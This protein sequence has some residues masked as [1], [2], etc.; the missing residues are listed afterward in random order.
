MS[1]LEAPVLLQESW[2]WHIS[3]L[4]SLS[5]RMSWNLGYWRG[6]PGLALSWVMVF[7]CSSPSAECLRHFGFWRHSD[8]SRRCRAE[9]APVT[10][11]IREWH[12]LLTASAHHILF[13]ALLA[14]P[15]CAV[16]NLAA[17]KACWAV[18][19]SFHS[20]GWSCSWW[21]EGP[22][23]AAAVGACMGRKELLLLAWVL[24]VAGASL[25][26][27]ESPVL[28]VKQED[29]RSPTRFLPSRISN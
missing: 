2:V 12:L 8:C 5:L 13:A 18:P 1:W 11:H 24:S 9:P 15:P 7:V 4:L 10:G 19:K 23:K 28:T 21:G 22:W 6:L 17:F 20:D 29:N 27:T 3:L 25:A 26:L 14:S 16:T